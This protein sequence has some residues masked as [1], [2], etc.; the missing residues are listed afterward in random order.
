MIN[1]NN[2]QRY[3]MLKNAILSIRKEKVMT[4][5]ELS[6]KACISLTTLR[7]IENTKNMKTVSLN[8]IF[9]IADALEVPVSHLVKM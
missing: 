4:Q 3:L 8:F 7:N 9:N 2:E 5:K 6:E 1:E